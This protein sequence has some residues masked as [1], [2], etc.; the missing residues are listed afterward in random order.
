MGKQAN[1]SGMQYVTRIGD[2]EA[3]EREARKR[4]EMRRRVQ[5]RQAEETR[6]AVQSERTAPKR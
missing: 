6:H 4:E 5:R 3:E 2:E 1:N